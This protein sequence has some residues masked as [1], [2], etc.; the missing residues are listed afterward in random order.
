M[1]LNSDCL[2]DTL[3]AIE[4]LHR[5]F[6]NDDGYLEKS[7]LWFDDLYSE[8]PAYNKED[9]FY[10]IYNLDQAKYIN[11]SIRWINACARDCAI[12][13]MTY[14]GHEFLEEIRDDKRWKRIKG[15]LSEIRDYSLSAINS[16]AKGMTSA[17]IA[18]YLSNG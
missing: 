3:I 13:H 12:N 5:I 8:L 16:V 7:V 15:A 11:A 18:A 17:A 4:K 9:V 6:I 1:K 10:A 2:R 14:S